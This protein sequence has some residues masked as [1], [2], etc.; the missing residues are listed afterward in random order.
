MAHAVACQYVH[1]DVGGRGF[2]EVHVASRRSRDVILERFRVARGTLF[3]VVAAEDAYFEAATSY[4][5]A[6]SELDAARYVLL[7]R[8]GR[9]LEVLRIDTDRLRGEGEF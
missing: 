5:Q 4:I 8:T 1:L 3:D 9:L 6:L 7:S 2:N